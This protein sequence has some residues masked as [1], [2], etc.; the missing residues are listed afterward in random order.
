VNRCRKII[1][2]KNKEN[3]AA[4]K[5]K[6]FKYADY[7][8]RRQDNMMFEYI[9][10]LIGRREEIM[11]E[12]R[13]ATYATEHNFSAT[14]LGKLTA[15]LTQIQENLSFIDGELETFISGYDLLHHST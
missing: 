6:V 2:E 14:Q 8:K 10:Y 15:T 5:S 12:A 9:G 3:K 1:R 4:L 11:L 13:R 7:E